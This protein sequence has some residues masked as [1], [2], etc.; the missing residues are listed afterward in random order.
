MSNFMWNMLPPSELSQVHG[1]R[2]APP[3]G[4]VLAGVIAQP[5]L[6]IYQHSWLSGEIPED[7]RF[8]NVTPIY[9]K[10]CKEDPGNYRSVSLTSVPEKVM[11][12]II[13]GEITRHMCG[14]QGVRPSQHRFIK[15]SLCSVLDQ[16]HLFL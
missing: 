12:Q 3:Y 9:K 7:W 11:E 2:S 6:A 4:A 14:I 15:G 10:G 1:T 8:A 13:L 16:P 5:L